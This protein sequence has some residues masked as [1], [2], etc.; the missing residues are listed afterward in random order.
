MPFHQRTNIRLVSNVRATGAARLLQ[1]G[2]TWT[3][4]ALR[5]WPLNNEYK[6]SSKFTPLF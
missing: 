2:A 5:S 3:Q 4:A 1:R 6:I